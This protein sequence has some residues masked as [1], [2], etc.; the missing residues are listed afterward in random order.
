MS[1]NRT[2][3]KATDRCGLIA[4]DQGV[5]GAFN[6]TAPTTASGSRCRPTRWLAVRTVRPRSAGSDRARRVCDHRAWPTISTSLGM[7]SVGGAAAAGSSPSVGAGSSGG[8]GVRSNRWMNSSAPETP[9]TAAWWILPIRATLPSWRP[10]TTWI[11]HSGR[12]RSSGTPTMAPVRSVSSRGPP[13]AGSDVATDV[14]V[15]VEVRIL[16]PQ[17]VV[18]VERHRHDPAAK[19]GVADQAAGD[20][21]LQL[22]ERV[23][24]RHR[25]RIDDGGDGDV[26]VHRGRLERQECRIQA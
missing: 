25:R 12:A 9:S 23:G 7:R 2:R 4:A 14:V 3:A 10:S 6:G 16:D 20:E 8:T 11:S 22:V 26:E 5:R 19:R 15:E 21:R 1:L 13:G 17:R 18:E 24:R